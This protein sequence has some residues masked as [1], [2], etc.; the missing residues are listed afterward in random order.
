MNSG[1]SAPQIEKLQILQFLIINS[2][3]LITPV[4]LPHY[5]A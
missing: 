1:C 2:Q 5:T 4:S 3:F